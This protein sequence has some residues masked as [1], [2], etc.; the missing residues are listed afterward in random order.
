MSQALPNGTVPPNG[1]QAP[2]N[3]APQV[4]PESKGGKT[5]L[6]YQEA[7]E[8]LHSLTIVLAPIT[9]AEAAKEEAKE[10]CLR[11]LKAGPFPTVKRLY[12]RL[13]AFVNAGDEAA[14]FQISHGEITVT[15]KAVDCAV[16]LGRAEALRTALTA[17]GIGAG[18][19]LLLLLL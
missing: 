14:T 15:Q 19:T 11:E 2:P 17:T 1:S 5:A 8:L 7:K 9:A 13:L 10:A 3:G 6:S 16:G 18:G 4:L 12:D